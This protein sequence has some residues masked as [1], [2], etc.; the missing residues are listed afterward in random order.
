[1]LRQKNKNVEIRQTSV[2]L[3]EGVNR[4]KETMGRVERTLYTLT[5]GQANAQT[6]WRIL[7]IISLLGGL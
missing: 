2:S 6:T 3:T 5:S 7:L 4:T 1:M